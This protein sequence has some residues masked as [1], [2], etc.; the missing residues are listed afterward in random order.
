MFIAF[1]SISR[2]SEYLILQRIHIVCYECHCRILLSLTVMY[3]CFTKFTI[4]CK[5]VRIACAIIH[6]IWQLTFLS[7]FHISKLVS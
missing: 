5:H 4:T 3:P 7:M 2:I 1:R 6:L